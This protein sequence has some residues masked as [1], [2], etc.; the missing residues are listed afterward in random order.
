[1]PHVAKRVIEVRS[2]QICKPAETNVEFGTARWRESE[3]DEVIAYSTKCSVYTAS[4]CSTRDCMP[5]AKRNVTAA[6]GWLDRKVMIARFRLGGCKSR[7]TVHAMDYRKWQWSWWVTHI[8]RSRLR[9]GC[10]AN[11]KDASHVAEKK[12]NKNGGYDSCCPRRC[13]R[14]K[15]G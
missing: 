3:V 9:T 4:V 14:K 5:H 6:R 11:R 13:G 10:T 15:R 8:P 12:N 7:L 2:F 1:M